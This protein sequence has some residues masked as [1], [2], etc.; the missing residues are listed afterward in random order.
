MLTQNGFLQAVL[1]CVCVCVKVTLPPHCLLM[2]LPAFLCDLWL[3]SKP[4]SDRM[5]SDH[6]LLPLPPPPTC[7]CVTA[8]NVSFCLEPVF[9]WKRRL[10]GLCIFIYCP[11]VPFADMSRSLKCW[12]H[13]ISCVDCAKN[14]H[15]SL[16]GC[17]YV[18]LNIKL[19]FL[20]AF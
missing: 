2:L 3:Q 19:K 6:F 9:I 13:E 18:K 4:S 20:V 5:C 12:R 10:V 15:E 7:C 16:K 8:C 11:I 14:L 17:F 1:A